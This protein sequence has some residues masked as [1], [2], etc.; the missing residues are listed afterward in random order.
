LNKALLANRANLYLL[1]RP[2]RLGAPLETAARSSSVRHRPRHDLA[3]HIHDE[4]FNGIAGR[5]GPQHL[6]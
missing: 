5:A 1:S 2:I 6:R 4:K 3:G